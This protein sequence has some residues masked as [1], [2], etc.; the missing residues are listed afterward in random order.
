MKKKIRKPIVKK[1]E[2]NISA[3]G[4]GLNFGL[5]KTQDKKSKAPQR[6]YSD[7]LKSFLKNLGENPSG[8][9]SRK[10]RMGLGGVMSCNKSEES[11]PCPSEAQLEIDPKA[12]AFKGDHTVLHPRHKS[13]DVNSFAKEMVI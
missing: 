11:I 8:T 9:K 5:G 7:N 1:T 3:H 13:I 10:S 4:M 12:L 6:L 2:N